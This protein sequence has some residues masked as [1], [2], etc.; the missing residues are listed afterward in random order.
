MRLYI[1]LPMKV[2]FIGESMP[3]LIPHLYEPISEPHL[4]AKSWH[5]VTNI[6][7]AFVLKATAK[8]RLSP[9]PSLVPRP[10][11]FLQTIIY[12]R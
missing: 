10:H 1:Q 6:I 9:N 12:W 2:V 3:A 11:H 5:M 4:S 7:R 8:N